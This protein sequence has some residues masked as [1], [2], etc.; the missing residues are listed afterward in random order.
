M[1]WDD[2][3]VNESEWFLRYKFHAT[4]ALPSHGST[5]SGQLHQAA[6]PVRTISVASSAPEDTANGE[7]QRAVAPSASFAAAHDWL[8]HPESPEVQTQRTSA[9]VAAQPQALLPKQ[10]PSAAHAER[11]DSPRHS[12]DA[13]PPADEQGGSA[14]RGPGQGASDAAAQREA[15]TSTV[16][17]VVDEL[18]VL[19]APSADEAESAGAA[20]AEGNAE[21]AGLQQMEGNASDKQSDVLA[22]AAEDE[23][24]PAV[25]AEQ[26]SD[27]AADALAETE[28]IAPP[29]DAEE[30]P[31][32]TASEQAEY[33]A[34]DVSECNV[35]ES[36]DELPEPMPRESEGQ[37]APHTEQY[38]PAA[39]SLESMD[40]DNIASEE[41]VSQA[42]S[43]DDVS[44]VRMQSTDIPAANTKVAE[45][46]ESGDMPHAVSNSAQAAE[47]MD[48]HIAPGTQQ[49]SIAPGAPRSAAPLVDTLRAEVLAAE[50]ANSNSDASVQSAAQR[51]SAQAAQRSLTKTQS[52]PTER[53]SIQSLATGAS[54][55]AEVLVDT[56]RGQ[57]A[58][59]LDE[60]G[61]L[62]SAE[63][64][65]PGSI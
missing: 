22:V 6:T 42:A 58:A 47:R 46:M 3:N 37:S 60:L 26:V 63:L 21:A 52:L 56:L 33:S 1:Q 18:M 36:S 39:A 30:P 5:V 49:A 53:P 17:R 40:I 7:D 35:V 51:T 64:S 62:D 57:I 55:E 43:T 14:A 10:V 27:T 61:S 48:N 54:A 4:G 31:N 8:Q 12:A 44:S 19:P 20:S 34:D 9:D 11:T 24:A 45:T 38:V 28:D 25:P 59:E 50:P 13:A 41:V 23:T 15:S 32:G 65:L 2:N 29:Q 16:D